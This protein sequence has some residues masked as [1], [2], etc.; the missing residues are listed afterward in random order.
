MLLFCLF[1]RVFVRVFVVLN[2][3]DGLGALTDAVDHVLLGAV[4]VDVVLEKSSIPTDYKAVRNRY[5]S[6]AQPR[7][8]DSTNSPE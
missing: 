5:V 1:F 2:H 6:Y 8:K 7:E 3:G 4:I